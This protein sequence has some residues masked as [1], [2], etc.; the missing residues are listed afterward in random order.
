MSITFRTE[1]IPSSMG[2]GT[3]GYRGQITGRPDGRTLDEI[4]EAVAEHSSCTAMQIASIFT[5]CFNEAIRDACRTGRNQ[6]L[7]EYATL[8]LTLCGRF[9]GVDDH[10]DPTRHRFEFKLTPRKKLKKPATRFA[11]ENIVRSEQIIINSIVGEFDGQRIADLRSMIWGRETLCTGSYL[12]L[13][14]GTVP[15]WSCKLAGGTEC[16]GALDVCENDTC[17]LNFR[18]P[19]EIPEAAIGR[20]V[21]LHFT[22]RGRSDDSVPVSREYAVHLY[23]AAR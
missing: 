17:I 20:T 8:G 3:G 11:V 21:K 13:K 1:P 22:F 15:T 23:P 7:G 19:A 2:R 10:F 14:E 4:A 6:I 9:D 16:S 18:W 12:L 5:D